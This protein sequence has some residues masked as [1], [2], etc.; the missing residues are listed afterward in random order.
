MCGHPTT[1]RPRTAVEVQDGLVSPEWSLRPATVH[2]AD[3]MADLKAQ[4]MRPDLERL[5]Y[6]DQQWARQRFLDTYIAANTS[7]IELEGDVAGVIAL[8]A[9]PDALWVEHFY[10]YPHA[11]GR[12]I[13]GH[14][15]EH[16]MKER[17][18]H[19]PFMLAIDRGSSARHLY[20]RHGFVY[21]YDDHNGVDQVFTSGGS[22]RL[23]GARANDEAHR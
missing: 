19:R 16:V 5:G 23:P 15:L 20:E 1:E 7:V 21:Q 22:P 11:Q 14:V 3:W 17:R 6:W 8:R 9:E 12:G 18:D 13:G 10:L 4:A 2:D